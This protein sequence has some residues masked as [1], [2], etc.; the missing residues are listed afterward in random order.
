MLLSYIKQE[1]EHYPKNNGLPLK[2]FRQESGTIKFVGREVNSSHRIKS[3][4]KIVEERKV[5]SIKGADSPTSHQTQK[6][7]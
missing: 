6:L 1:T 4:L 2:I 5:F 7:V 3:A